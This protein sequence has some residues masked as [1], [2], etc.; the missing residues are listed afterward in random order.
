MS[1]HF[2]NN[3]N[4]LY[5]Q[6]ISILALCLL[7]SISNFGQNIKGHDNGTQPN[8]LLIIAD[9]LGYSDIG[10]YGG[11]IAT[12]NLDKLAAQ[13]TKFSNFH[14]LP[15]CAPT[16]AVLLTGTDNHIAG[17]GAQVP[18]GRT[19]KQASASGFE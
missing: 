3:I 17:L 12:P 14:T 8:I 9:D 5:K 19:Q 11:E 2:R 10:A 13:G 16:R 7:F 15:T 1:A 6:L 4:Y 18:A